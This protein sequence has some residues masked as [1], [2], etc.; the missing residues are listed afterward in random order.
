ML[1]PESTVRINEGVLVNRI[2][3][4]TVLLSRSTGRYY[5]LNDVATRMWSLLAA[6]ATVAGVA[7]ALVEEF[8]VPGTRV[9]A[10]LLAF[11]RELAAHG[12]V[13][14]SES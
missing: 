11:V 9:A 14:V 1:G 8:D 2:V 12:L 6:G 3:D 5:C 7:D 13:S 10:D 4:E